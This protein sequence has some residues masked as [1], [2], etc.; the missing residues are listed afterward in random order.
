MGDFLFSDMV[1]EL[2]VLPL[3]EK[4]KIWRRTESG[5]E[6]NEFS[7]GHGNCDVFPQ[8][9]DTEK[10]F[11]NVGLELGRKVWTGDADLGVTSLWRTSEAKSPYKII[12]RGQTESEES[13]KR[14]RLEP[15]GNLQVVLWSV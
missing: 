6:D 14:L 1:A 10:A 15:W 4:G 13:E 3:T 2:T 9:S 8:H 5:G 11:G 12:P 7:F